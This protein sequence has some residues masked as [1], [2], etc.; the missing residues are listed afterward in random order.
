[1]EIGTILVATDNCKMTGGA[2]LAWERNKP[3][4]IVG[5]EYEVLSVEGHEF[6]VNSE[7]FPHH[8]F[9]IDKKQKH[10]YRNFFTKK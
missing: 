5:K 8:F 2:L 1:M 9:S 3:A 7:V 10:F 6:S 4:L